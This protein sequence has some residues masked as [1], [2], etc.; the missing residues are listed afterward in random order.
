M[1]EGSEFESRSGQEFFLLHIV[2][3]GSGVHPASY[4]MVRGFSLGAKR[5]RRVEVKKIWIYTSTPLYVFMV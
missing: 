5:P 2:Q 1:I 3:N 4:P